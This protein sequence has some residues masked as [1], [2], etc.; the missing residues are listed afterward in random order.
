MPKLR[1]HF[2]ALMLAFAVSFGQCGCVALNIPSERAHDP[3]DA[4]GILG[5]WKKGGASTASQH[6]VFDEFTNDSYSGDPSCSDGGALGFDPFD[7]NAIEG[8][9]TEPPE[10][11]WPRFHPVPTRPVFG[12]MPTADGH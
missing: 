4:G 5:P 3:A 1:P 7:P 9:Q 8:G 12:A 11:P 2:A 10:V 6:T